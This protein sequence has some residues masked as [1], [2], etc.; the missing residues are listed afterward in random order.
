M[1]YL[2]LFHKVRRFNLHDKSFATNYG[3][4]EEIVNQA[5]G[6]FSLTYLSSCQNRLQP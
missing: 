5:E 1:S 2:M 6:P 3:K 4:D